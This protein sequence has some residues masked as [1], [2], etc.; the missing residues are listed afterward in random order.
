MAVWALQQLAE[1]EAWAAE[2][3]R[4]ILRETDAVVRAEWG[5]EAREAP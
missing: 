3:N 5:V 2:R 4:Y 1:P